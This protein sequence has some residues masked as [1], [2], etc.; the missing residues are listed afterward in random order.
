MYVS[1]LYLY[2]YSLYIHIYTYIHT[3][4]YIHTHT[5]THTYIFFS[6]TIFH[7][8]QSGTSPQWSECPSLTSQQITNAREGVEKSEP[9]FTVSGEVN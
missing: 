7:H 6:H 8:V 3:Y 9:S 1:I 4:I 5:Y 2:L